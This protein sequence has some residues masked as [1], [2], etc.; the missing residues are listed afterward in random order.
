MVITR[1]ITIGTITP[2]TT[3]DT[4]TI[5]G[6]TATH[7]NITATPVALGS[8]LVF[9]STNA[10]PVGLDSG[11]RKLGSTQRIEVTMSVISCLFRRKTLLINIASSINPMPGI[12]S[13]IK[14]SPS[15]RYWTAKVPSA[16]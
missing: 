13:G 5:M 2:T 9:N 16:R 8:A 15:S 14:S 4:L 6:I 12:R 7:T 3:G 1:A 10:N 11:N